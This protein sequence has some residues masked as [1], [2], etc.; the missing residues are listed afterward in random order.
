VGR[1]GRLLLLLVVVVRAGIS[2][3]SGA[4][5]GASGD[6]CA[7]SSAG[8]G[9]RG[10]RRGLGGGSGVGAG[11]GTRVTTCDSLL[12]RRRLLLRGLLLLLW[13]LL[14][15]LLRLLVLVLVLVPVGGA[16]AGAANGNARGRKHLGRKRKADAERADHVVLL[17]V[18]GERLQ[19]TVLLQGG[20]GERHGATADEVVRADEGL[21]VEFKRQVGLRA[22]ERKREL[23]VQR[24]RGEVLA[25]ASFAQE[26][27]GQ[28]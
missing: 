16:W 17:V 9:A 6:A 18:Q 5:G 27:A 4:S 11:S 14:L 25:G 1:T 24:H 8:A 13:G 23:G 2:A 22:V 7:H 12:C 26:W 19:D 15:L 20:E 10:G 21:D 3:S 28:W